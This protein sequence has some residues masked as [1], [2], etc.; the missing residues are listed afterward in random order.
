MIIKIIVKFSIMMIITITMMITIRNVGMSAF[1]KKINFIK[2]MKNLKTIS[3]NKIYQK[4]NC[5]IK[6]D[7]YE[8]QMIEA[9]QKV[10][11]Q[12]NK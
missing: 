6:T 8:S 12:L 4:L 11:N 10:H 1:Q 7:S 2:K 9:Q 3:F 5:E